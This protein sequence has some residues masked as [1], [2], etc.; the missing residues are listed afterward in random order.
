MAAL[1]TPTFT[2]QASANTCINTNVTYT[3]QASQSNYVWS[4]D[5][6]SGID[7]TITTGGTVADNTV[8]LQWLTTGS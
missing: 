6:T 4:F 8:T 1:P 3:T 7:Y 5:G 2:A